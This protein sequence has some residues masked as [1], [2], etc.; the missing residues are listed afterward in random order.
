MSDPLHDD[1]AEDAGRSHGEHE[2]HDDQGDGELFAVADDVDAGRLLD[3]VAGEGHHVLEHADDEAAQHRAARVADAAD[4][5]AGEGVEQDA[6]HHVGIEIDDVGHHDAG[7]RADRRGQPP[8]QRQHPVD[9][10]ADQA[11]H[12]RVLRGRAHGK[13][14]RRVAEEDEQEAEHDQRDEHDAQL[15]RPDDARDAEAA[16][17]ERRGIFLDQ[18]APDGAR[19]RVEDREQADEDHDD[20]QHGRI[21]KRSQDDALDDDA[22]HEGQ[23]HR[24]DEREPEAQ[25]PAHELPADVGR[26]HRHL[27]L[28]EIDV[29]GRHVDHD[30]RQRDAGIDGAVGQA[31]RDLLEEL[32]HLLPQYPRYDLRMFSSF[33]TTAEGPDITTW[34][35]SST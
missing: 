10:H 3:L 18:V 17:G 28:G 27:A 33:F 4:Q 29:V 24:Q 21:V 13:P 32:F 14:E 7:D 25:P 2:D 12:L 15:V 1:A 26:E 20:G 19:D 35:V 8:A 23:H 6:A 9:A 30:Q 5:G 11:G 16:L 34:P 31:G 22:Q